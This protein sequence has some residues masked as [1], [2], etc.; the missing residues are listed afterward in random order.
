MRRERY[1]TGSCW[2]SSAVCVGTLCL[3]MALPH[4]QAKT[5]KDTSSVSFNNSPVHV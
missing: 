2:C 3:L 4:C 5:L 1:G